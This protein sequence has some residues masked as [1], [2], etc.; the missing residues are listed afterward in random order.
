MMK[1]IVM[2]FSQVI[3]LKQEMLLKIINTNTRYFIQTFFLFY[4]I[5]RLVDIKYF[6]FFINY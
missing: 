5:Y 4:I 3:K 1:I 2:I 6:S